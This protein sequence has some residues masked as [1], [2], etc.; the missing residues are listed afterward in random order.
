MPDTEDLDGGPKVS[1]D[2]WSLCCFARKVAAR[3]VLRSFLRGREG[4]STRELK[5]R[6][7]SPGPCRPETGGNVEGVG[8]DRGFEGGFPFS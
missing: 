1:A 2:R 3:D 7:T 8:D 4:W 5:R 6:S